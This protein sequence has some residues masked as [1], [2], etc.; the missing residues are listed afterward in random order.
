MRPQSEIVHTTLVMSHL[1]IR[2]SHQEEEGISMS[3]QYVGRPLNQDIEPLVSFERARVEDDPPPAERMCHPEPRNLCVQN[4]SGIALERDVLDE[5]AG[6]AG[7]DPG[8]PL[9][10]AGTDRND[11]L[12]AV[13]HSAFQPFKHANDRREATVVAIR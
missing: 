5:Q 8:H 9:H 7:I 2:S 1:C 3:S 4:C 13:D 12:A 10:Q 6:D 11:N